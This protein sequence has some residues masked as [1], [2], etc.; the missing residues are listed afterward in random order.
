M[1]LLKKGP[2]SINTFFKVPSDKESLFVAQI[3]QISHFKA[4]IDQKHIAKGT[5]VADPFVIA[6]AHSRGGC[7]VTQESKKP[8]GAKIPNVCEYFKIEC[9]DLEGF[10]EME[11]WTF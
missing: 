7:V 8:N 9:T 11:G 2:S 5:P 1:I 6:A 10:M 3:F 4:L